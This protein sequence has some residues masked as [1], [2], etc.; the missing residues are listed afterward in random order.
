MKGRKEHNR[1][2]LLI[3]KGGGYIEKHPLNKKKLV[4]GFM[5]IYILCKYVIMYTWPPKSQ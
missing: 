2:R 3:N 4:K 5:Q 1:R